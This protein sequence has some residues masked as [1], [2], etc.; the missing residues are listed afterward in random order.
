MKLSISNPE[1]PWNILFLFVFYIDSYRFIFHYILLITLLQ[2]S[3]FLPLCPSP[4][5]TPTPSGSPP[6]LFMSMSLAYRFFGYSVSYTVLYYFLC[7]K[8]LCQLS[9]LCSLLQ[10]W[11]YPMDSFLLCDIEW[12]GCRGWDGGSI[13]K[14]CILEAESPAPFY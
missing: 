6:P 10:T 1:F 11:A 8:C 4:P 13:G 7:L 9:S 2:L 14:V 5:S 3:W 12:S